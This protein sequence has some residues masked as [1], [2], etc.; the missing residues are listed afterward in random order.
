MA[1]QSN[2]SLLSC[3]LKTYS[4]YI[5]YIFFEIYNN[6]F[7]FGLKI[8]IYYI[9]LV[10]KINIYFHTSKGIELNPEQIKIPTNKKATSFIGSKSNSLP[11]KHSSFEKR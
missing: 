7:Y 6:N 8:C 4:F 2:V 10:N 3:Y 9:N 5:Y 11:L 1:I